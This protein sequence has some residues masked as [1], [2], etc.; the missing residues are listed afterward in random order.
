MHPYVLVAP[1]RHSIPVARMHHPRVP[2][3]PALRIHARALAPILDPVAR[4]ADNRDCCR[5]TRAQLPAIVPRDLVAAQ[6][7]RCV[8]ARLLRHD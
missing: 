1:K 7:E 8:R 5:G 4:R 6:P 3:A 2:C